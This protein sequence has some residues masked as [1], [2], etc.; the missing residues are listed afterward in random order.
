MVG[1]EGEEGH[2]D[3]G[4]GG[5]GADEAGVGDGR[6]VEVGWVWDVSVGGRTT[7]W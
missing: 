2:A 4:A 3:E 1:E 5:V 6:L 7:G